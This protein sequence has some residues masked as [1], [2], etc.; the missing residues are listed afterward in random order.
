[1]HYSWNPITKRF[2]VYE[3]YTLI[4]KMWWIEGDLY[5]CSDLDTG[6]GSNSLILKELSTMMERIEYEQFSK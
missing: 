5:F 3:K 6:V 4:G 2:K 1:M